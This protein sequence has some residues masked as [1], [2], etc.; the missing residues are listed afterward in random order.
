M[1]GER[2]IRLTIALTAVLITATV[3]PSPRAGA[4]TQSN[5]EAAAAFTKAESVFR[6]DDF[7]GAAT[8]FRE[9]LRRFPDNPRAN[10]ARL[11]LGIFD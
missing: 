5:E 10:T 1:A 6:R 4:A 11:Q 7:A 8:A 2:G 3:W 9:A